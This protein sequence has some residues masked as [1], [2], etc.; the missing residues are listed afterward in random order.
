MASVSGVI[1]VHEHVT[2]RVWTSRC[3]SHGVADNAQSVET[4]RLGEGDNTSSAYS[5]CIYSVLAIGTHDNVT[6]NVDYFI[7]SVLFGLPVSVACV[8]VTESVGKV[9]WWIRCW[10]SINI[11]KIVQNIETLYIETHAI[12]LTIE[13]K[14]I[15]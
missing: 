7:K 10:R 15:K 6:G 3:C 13:R 8:A 12:A 9:V 5:E 2:Q 1:Q 14:N 4:D 11:V